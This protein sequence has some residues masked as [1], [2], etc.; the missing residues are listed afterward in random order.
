MH[1]YARDV[2]KNRD[3]I[4]NFNPLNSI[5]I[6]VHVH[7]SWFDLLDDA[8]AAKGEN[9]Q[10]EYTHDILLHLKWDTRVCD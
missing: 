7:L 2:R 6:F 10:F 3:I 5:D 8:K 9:F 4:K 1:F